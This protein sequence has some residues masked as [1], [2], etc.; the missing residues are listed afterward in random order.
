[1]EPSILI[2]LGAGHHQAPGWFQQIQKETSVQNPGSIF[3][4]VGGLET[5]ERLVEQFYAG[6]EGDPL[7]RPIYP[8]DLQEARRHLALFLAQYFGGPPT[9]SEE[10]GHPRLRMRHFRFRITR[11]ARDAWVSHMTAA[12]VVMDFPPAVGDELLSYFA[13]TAT[14]LINSP[15]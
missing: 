13:N 3:E 14:L 5:F 12:V 2:R 1:L 11:A 4:Q 10:R 7:L 9:Y 8:D 6:V 15:S